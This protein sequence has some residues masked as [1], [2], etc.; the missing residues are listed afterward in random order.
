MLT[1]AAEFVTET[2]RVAGEALIA[3]ES[4]NPYQPPH[5]VE[6]SHLLFDSRI[7]VP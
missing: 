4:K 2:F 3:E 5:L 6:A 7:K 1:A